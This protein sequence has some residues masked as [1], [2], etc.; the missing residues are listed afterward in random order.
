MKRGI[1]KQLLGLG[2]GC[3]ALF[4]A[5]GQ[6]NTER[7]AG[8]TPTPSAA[9]EATEAPEATVVPSATAKATEAPEA[10]VVP[11]A[12]AKATEAPEAT[13][14][15]SPTAEATDV[16]EAT[17]VPSPTPEVTKAPEATMTPIPTLVEGIALD[18]K[19]FPDEAF[20]DYLEVYVDLDG[21]HILSQQERDAVTWLGNAKDMGGEDKCTYTEEEDRQLNAGGA[22]RSFDGIEYFEN[23]QEIQLYTWSQVEALHLDNPKLE[24]VAVQAP[25]LKEFSLKNAK[26]LRYLVYYSCG[27]DNI[28]WDSIRNLEYMQ[29]V[30]M[31]VD[32]PALLKNEKLSQIRMDNC[33]LGTEQGKVDFSVLPKLS[34]VVIYTSTE[35]EKVSFE[36]MIF[37][38]N[39]ELKWVGLARGLTEE[40]VLPDFETDYWFIGEGTD[41]SVVY[42]AEQIAQYPETLEPGYIPLNEQYFPDMAFRRYLYLYVDANKDRM[43]S[44]EECEAVT[45]IRNAHWDYDKNEAWND[46]NWDV[47][48]EDEEVRYGD[49]SKISNLQGIEYFTNLYEIQLRGLVFDEEL[50]EVVLSNPKLEILV[51]S[52]EGNV[53]RMDITGCKRLRHCEIDYVPN[54]ADAKLRLDWTGLTHIVEYWFSYFVE[55][56]SDIV[57]AEPTP[58]PT[59]VLPYPDH[60]MDWKDEKLEEAMREVTGIVDRDI[61]LS[62]VYEITYLYLWGRE[63][64]DISAL[65]ELPNVEELKIGNN[66]IS[67]I[68]ALAEMPNLNWL[69]MQENE[70]SDLSALSTALELEVIKANDNQIKDVSPL[71]D[72]PKLRW[73]EMD[74]NQISD[75][76]TLKSLKKLKDLRLSNNQITELGDLSGMKKLEKVHL[77]GNRITTVEG[78]HD[79]PKL[80]VLL[81]DDNQIGTV[82][83]SGLSELWCLTMN[84]NQIK[85]ITLSELPKLGILELS[86]NGILDVSGL[87]ELPE[88]GTL[89]L[90]DNPVE[91][92]ELVDFVKELRFESK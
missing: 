44:P 1:R 77:N 35:P 67:D 36:K 82:Q 88:L 8:N 72:L 10:T 12:T 22:I 39:K 9:A 79:L 65:A 91:N 81:L 15:P 89:D 21:D 71:G 58:T 68:S 83:L 56:E 63:I 13:V 84:R 50:T 33:D 4:V 20:R 29:I 17:L 32:V 64:T 62:D 5:C 34:D 73:I 6:E 80:G 78:L 7:D 16:P 26:N 54:K 92:I 86:D 37:A 85:D 74:N 87:T 23:L 11:S 49:A 46:A 45:R 42:Y 70:I 31:K 66:K 53:E 59:P 19:H 51:I 55:P 40:L 75:I 43:L 69:E 3:A 24:V 2:L 30:E 41:S 76:S 60:A 28:D 48:Y 52:F 14:V 61:M 47:I 57:L 90:T 38:D 27:A 18:E 25:S